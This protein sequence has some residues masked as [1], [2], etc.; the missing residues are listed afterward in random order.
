M[1]RIVIFLFF[2]SSCNLFSQQTTILNQ[3]TIGGNNVDYGLSSVY[4]TDESILVAGW[5]TSGISGDKSLPSFG[6]GDIWLVKLNSD[7]TIAWQQVYGGSGDDVGGKIIKTSDGGYILGCFSNS[8]ISGNKSVAAY[9]LGDYWVLKLDA[10]GAIEWQNVYGG[11]DVEEFYGLSETSGGDFILAGHSKSSISGVKTENSYGLQDYWIIKI[12]VNGNLI[13]DKT[14]GGS[15]VDKLNDIVI[16]S[17]GSI[18]LAGHSISDIS[19]LKSENSYGDND[20]WVVK[21]DQ[22]GGVVWD[23]TLGGSTIEWYPNINCM[24]NSVYVGGESYSGISGLKSEDTFGGSDLWL[25]KM[26]KDGNIVWDKTIGGNNFEGTGEILETNDYQLLLAFYS[27]SDISG[28][29]SENSNSGSTDYW[30]VSIDTNGNFLW[31]KTIGGNQTDVPYS[32][33]EKADNN[34]ILTGYSDSDIS[35]DKDENSRGME[36]YWIVEIS[37]NVGLAEESGFDEI[38]F[39]PNPANNKICFSH[40]VDNARIVNMQ[41]RVVISEQSN[42]NTIYMSEI[43]AGVYFVQFTYEGIRYNKKLIVN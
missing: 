9:G 14:I 19:G 20:F 38:S 3:A 26:D 18:L 15:D 11:S 31:D 39:Y 16:D 13:W 12:D 17:E 42:T 2:A 41:G 8:P 32:I 22:N 43:P 29:K 37:S 40:N 30:I 10:N 25:I 24:G 33:H 6:G 4:N 7:L 28:Y 36:D 5:T 21:L 1:K 23:K 34:Y 27:S 35:G